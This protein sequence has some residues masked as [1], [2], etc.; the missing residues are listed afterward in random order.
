MAIQIL[1]LAG[2]LGTRLGSLTQNTPKALVQICGKPFLFHQ[3]KW[4]ARCGIEEVILSTGYRADQIRDYAQD[5]SQ[6]GLKIHYVDE[7]KELR[8]T[9]GAI[10]YVYEQ[11]IL[12]D[13]FLVTYGDS[14]LPIDYR[15]VWKFFQTCQES[16]LMTVLEN[17]G[18]WDTSNVCLSEDHS[19]VSLYDKWI[20]PK[21]TTMR[22]IDYGLSAF[23]RDI[24]AQKLRSGE[25]SDLADLFHHLSKKND[26]AAYPV[27]ERFY[28]VGSHSGI[29]DLEGFL[30]KTQLR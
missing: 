19:K 16:A 24:I 6:W 11:G 20:N 23:R 27:T 26:L 8:G 7:G 10:R 4:L 12:Q 14:Y 1:I 9:G 5:G 15:A 3:L 17:E 30:Q 29:A 13:S 18:K 21:P 28:E 25:K 22:Y 2:G